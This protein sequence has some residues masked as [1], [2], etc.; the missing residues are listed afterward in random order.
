[1]LENVLKAGDV[2]CLWSFSAVYLLAH[3]TNS[4]LTQP[5]TLTIN[6]FVLSSLLMLVV[7]VFSADPFF[8][9]K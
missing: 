1:M 2:V 6:L 5:A 4:S 7:S 3:S 8:L 9:L